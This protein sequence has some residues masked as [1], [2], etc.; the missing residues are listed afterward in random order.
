MPQSLK[1]R[2]TE[3]P[4]WWKQLWCRHRNRVKVTN[5]A[6]KTTWMECLTCGRKSGVPQSLSK[7]GHHWNR[8]HRGGDR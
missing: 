1:R 8:H 3:M 2:N 7:P 4:V 5:R 6:N